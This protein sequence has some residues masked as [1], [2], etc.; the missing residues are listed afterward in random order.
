MSQSSEVWELDADEWNLLQRHF[1]WND[2]ILLECRI[3]RWITVEHG[4]FEDLI[5]YM[6][7][8]AVFTKWKLLKES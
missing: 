2:P 4:K 3:K 7:F 8:N 6:I 5:C 1:K